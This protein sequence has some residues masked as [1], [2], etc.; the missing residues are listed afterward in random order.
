MS[1]LEQIDKERIPQH[2]AVIMDGNGRWAKRLGKDRLEGHAMGAHRAREIVDAANKIGVKYITL[3]AFSIENWQ[4]PE[5]EVSGLMSL[6]AKSVAS[7]FADLIKYNMRLMTIGDNSMLPA[8]V[9]QEIEEA[10]RKSAQNTGIT[11]VIALSYG[12]RYEM[13]AAVKKMLHKYESQRFDIDSITDSDFESCLYT[14]GMPDPELLI[15]TSGEVR[16]SNFLLWQISY[17]ELYFTDVLWPDFGEEEFFK[18]IVDYQRRERRFG[19]TSQQI[20][21]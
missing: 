10:C 20:K 4:R 12:S 21:A 2:V 5:S 7:Q 6:L 11:V 14:S 19:K 1:F 17:S 3:Y 8:D 18:A 15:R 16:I 13:L 9:R